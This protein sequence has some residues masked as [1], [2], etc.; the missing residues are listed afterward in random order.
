MKSLRGVSLGSLG[1]Q[2]RVLLAAAT[3]AV[4]SACGGGGSQIDP[5]H[6]TRIITFGDESSYIGRDGSKYTVNGLDPVTNIESCAVNPIWVQSLATAFGLTYPQC[7]TNFSATPA[8]VMYATPGA[9]VADIVTQINQHFSIS[10]F[11]DKDL[12]TVLAGQ[13][14]ILDL[15]QQFPTQSEDALLAQAKTLGIA[16]ADQVNRV[17][18]AGGRVIV[19][20]LPDLGTTPFALNEQATRFDV[21]RA[22]LLTDLTSAF[23]IAMRLELLND[24]RLIGLVLLDES[25]ETAVKFPSAFGLT[26]VTQAACLT[27]VIMPACTEQTL[28]NGATGNTWL[29]ATPTLMSAIGQ[30]RLGSLALTRAQNN[31][32]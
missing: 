20:T 21:D 26:N 1:R 10:N 25:V 14:D 28:V 22:K 9:H 24:G 4:L 16:L 17:A 18:N 3:L 27:T 5:F 2:G 23:N 6:P 30:S 29:W 8:G 7:N 12:V 31:P 19:S 32:F 13:N 11:T 15:Y